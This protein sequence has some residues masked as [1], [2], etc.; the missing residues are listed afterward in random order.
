MIEFL[1]P[2]KKTGGLFKKMSTVKPYTCEY[3]GS[4]FT[5]EK[6]LSVHMCEKKRRRLQ[7]DEKRVQTGYYAFTRFYKL[8]AG[9]KKE[10][11]Y[12]DFCA[13]PY[14][15]AFVKFGS[16]VSNVRPL[17]PEK[18]VDYV[19]TSGVKLDHWCRDALYE[20]YATELVLKES[21]ETAV[22]R[23]IQTMMDWAT[24]VEAPWN[25]YFRYCSLNRV[26]RDI[27]DGKISPWLVLNCPSG[28]EMLSKFTDEQLEI[29]YTVIE[30]KHWALRFRRVPADVEIVKE[31]A[32]ESK[33]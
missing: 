23:S 29:V 26:T 18:Y 9:T 31:V 27:K 11:T 13:S 5:K 3:C 22:E 20:Q 14:Y 2:Q 15:N 6:T 16:F 4:S 33:L 8:S 1:A 19:V 32:K 28:K 7:K 25:D 30:P 17:Y 24:E 10:K 21:M 12:E